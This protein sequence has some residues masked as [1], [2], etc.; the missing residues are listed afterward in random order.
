LKASSKKEG[1][2]KRTGVLILAF[3]LGVAAQ[4][5]RADWSAVQRLTWTVGSSSSP[6]IAMD[7]GSTVH[8]VWHDLTPDNA[9]I[10]YK[11]STDGGTSW[12]PA[13]RLTW[14][15]GGSDDPAIV[16]DSNMIIHIVWSDDTPGS[17]EI[18]YKKGS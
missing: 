2:M 4:M 18:Y 5:A 17:A 16:T 8:V 3:G 9:E 12:S 1:E 7:S 13:K 15:S 10:Y 14:T 6:A 11:R